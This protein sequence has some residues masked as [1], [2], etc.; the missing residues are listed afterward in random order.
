MLL[1]G[2]VVVMMLMSEFAGAQESP[3]VAPPAES[4]AGIAGL[5]GRI[6][7]HPAEKLGKLSASDGQV[8]DVF[9]SAVAID[10]DTIVVGNESAE[11]HHN[12]QQG[13]AYV[14]VKPVDGWH[15]MTQTAK[16]T[17]SDGKEFDS[18]G[19]SV[20]VRG[21]TIAIGAYCNRASEGS[22]PGSIYIFEEPETGWAD[23]TETAK[24]TS[25][26]DF[27]AYG[28]ALG[29][30]VAIGPDYAV[31]GGA[32]LAANKAG[33]IYLFEKPV[34]GWKDTTQTAELT[35]SDGRPYN[36]LGSTLSYVGETLATGANGWPY[37]AG[38]ECCQGAAYIYTKPA[39]G[40]KTSTET[41]RL[42]VSD[43]HVNDQLGYS[44][45]LDPVG[46]HL[47]SGAPGD[48]IDGNFQQGAVYVFTKP[49]RGWKNTSAFRA[50]L[51]VYDGEGRN[52]FGVAVSAG[53]R[54]LAAGGPGYSAFHGAT[55]VYRRPS[56]GWK[57]TSRYG[58]RFTDHVKK[59]AF[60]GSAVALQGDI[61]VVGA[62][63][64]TPA[65]AAYVYRTGP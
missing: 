28:F 30:A 23:M 34:G 22:C 42:T 41:A 46:Q 21:H 26:D 38:S 53:N 62:Y 50:K 5:A 13:A 36:D 37:G 7:K 49:K 65:G 19:H 15:T 35:A 52:G 39:E 16:L 57:T 33:A 8:D 43:R 12:F 24:L 3:F 63:L 29:W 31:V 1:P 17:A 64:E 58:N 9:G 6:P 44:V 20:A 2:V 48:T 40:W 61:L 10:G 55:Y 45:S 4:R 54:Q 47:I 27:S 18:F 56:R 32:P 59:Y 11:I 60:F 25:S 51:T 14:F